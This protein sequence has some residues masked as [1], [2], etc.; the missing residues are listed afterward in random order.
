M[1]IA[2]VKRQAIAYFEYE[3]DQRQVFSR[4]RSA[5]LTRIFSIA[6]SSLFIHCNYKTILIRNIR[7][8]EQSLFSLFN[9]NFHASV[10]TAKHADEIIYCVQ[11]YVFIK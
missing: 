1:K 9:Y 5:K 11:I 8:P 3:L 10:F 6:A 7:S 2:V 4:V